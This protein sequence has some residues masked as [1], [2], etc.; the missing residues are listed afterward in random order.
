MVTPVEFNWECQRC[1]ACCQNMASGVPIL[2]KDI[3]RIAKIFE[4]SEKE[5]VEQYCDLEV[6][7]DRDDDV[8]IPLLTLKT[9]NGTCVLFKQGGCSIHDVKPYYCKTA[10]LISLVF[11]EQGL[12]NDFKKHCKGFG[13]GKR[14]T[15]PEIEAQLE[16]EQRLEKEYIQ[17]F[18]TEGYNWLN[19]VKTK[20]VKNEPK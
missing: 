4:F 14:Y 20:E 9:S 2:L 13:K 7:Q 6:I 16:I 17:E 5:F 15:L 3:R 12:Y 1:N 10:P 18:H 11:S 8:E 19:D